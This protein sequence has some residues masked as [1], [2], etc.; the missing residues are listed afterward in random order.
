MDELNTPVAS[1]EKPK[2]EKVPLIVSFYDWLE[3]VCLATVLVVLIFTFIG[4][5][6]NVVGES[7]T[8]TLQN[9]DQLIINGL[10]YTP[11]R[12]DIVVIQKESGYYQDELLVKRVIA[13]GG[14]TVTFDF[15]NW[16]VSVDGEVLDE[17]YI[18]RKPNESMRSGDL[19]GDTITVPEGYYF[20]MG[21]NRNDSSDSRYDTVGFVKEDEIVGKAIFRIQPFSSIGSLK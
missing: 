14:E 11:E 18:R 10:L 16:T 7:M 6:A 13:K 9:G 12:G 19:T 21:D 17:P 1:K 3:V 5:T 20:V 8:N 2:K 4:R 15:E